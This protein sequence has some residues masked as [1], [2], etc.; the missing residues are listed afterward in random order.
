MRK[1]KVNLPSVGSGSSGSPRRKR[2]RL[3]NC[4]NVPLPVVLGWRKL[5]LRLPLMFRIELLE[6]VVIV[7]E[8]CLVQTDLQGIRVSNKALVG[9]PRLGDNS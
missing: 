4:A 6:C 5:L 2:L 1:P 7:L 9:A 8:H 3:L